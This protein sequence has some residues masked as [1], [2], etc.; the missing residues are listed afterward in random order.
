MVLFAPFMR[1][2]TP[3]FRQAAHSFLAVLNHAMRK[4]PVAADTTAAHADE[5]C[6]GAAPAAHAAGP[7]DPGH[8]AAAGHAGRG[9]PRA[10]AGVATE[11]KFVAP[12]LRARWLLHRGTSRER[13]GKGVWISSAQRSWPAI[14]ASTQPITNALVRRAGSPVLLDPIATP[15]RRRLP[16]FAPERAA[17]RRIVLVAH[18]FGHARQRG[19]ATT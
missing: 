4:R 2:W 15:G 3:S 14:R 7:G 5:L 6:P 16:V 12:Q 1:A 13:R 17:E 11:T 18:F 10:D 8:W 19:I 9:G